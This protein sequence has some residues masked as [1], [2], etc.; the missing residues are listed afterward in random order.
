M[1][2]PNFMDGLVFYFI[3]WDGKPKVAV[4]TVGWKVQAVS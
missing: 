1:A 3:E 4:G 2:D